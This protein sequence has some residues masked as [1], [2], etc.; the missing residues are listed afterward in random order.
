[1][2]VPNLAQPILSK[3]FKPVQSASF[4]D[5]SAIMAQFSDEYVLNEI[6]SKEQGKAVHEH[7]VQIELLYPGNNLS[8]Y[9]YCFRMTDLELYE[10]KAR[11][12]VN[13]FPKQWENF[14]AQKEQMPEG[15]PIEIW[16]PMDKKRVFDLKSKHIHTVEQIAAMTD[17]TGP[18][19]GMD[20]RKFRDMAIATLK[21]TDGSVAISKL[22][23]ENDDLRT[24][25]NVQQE[26]I[27]RLIQQQNLTPVTLSTR[28]KTG[29]KP[30]KAAPPMPE[31]DPQTA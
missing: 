13:R 21:P 26:Q 6:K 4:G 12:F 30:N 14:L 22:N 19:I 17:Q 28:R 18:S 11:E 27:N 15:M 2:D 20:W 29:R 9:K 25:L 24:Q 23:K 31:G 5:D 1:M 7:F 3:T 10:S 16:P 8:T